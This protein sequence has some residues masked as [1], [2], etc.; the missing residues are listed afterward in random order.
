MAGNTHIEVI[1]P[2]A[3]AL[4]PKAITAVAR[5]GSLDGKTICLWWNCKARGDVALTTI[6]EILERRFKN[7]NFVRFSQ[8]YDHA[9]NFPERYDEVKKSGSVVAIAT[10]AD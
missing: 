4:P 7:V 9:R 10:T 5:P 3:N 6:A 2:V 8:Q 1:S